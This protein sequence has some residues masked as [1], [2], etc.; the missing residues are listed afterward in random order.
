MSEE[1]RQAKQAVPRAMI[2]TIIINGV[3]AYGIILVL[4]FKMGDPSAVLDS[5]YPIIPICINATGSLKAATALVSGL[6]I[7][8]FCVIAASLASVGRITWAWARDGVLPQWLA[9]VSEH[10]LS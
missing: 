1:V 9:V 2:L 4:L 8:T 5:T 7:V 3:M 6:I 10:Q